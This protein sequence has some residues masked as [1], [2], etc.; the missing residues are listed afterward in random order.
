MK[1]INKRH[2]AISLGLIVA[3]GTGVGIVM[4]MIAS[5]HRRTVT[6][7]P[8]VARRAGTIDAQQAKADFDAQVSKYRA[9]GGLVAGEQM[10]QAEEAHE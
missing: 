9:A 6:V 5:P 2:L 10:A 7:A 1:V 4:F 3:A 8:A